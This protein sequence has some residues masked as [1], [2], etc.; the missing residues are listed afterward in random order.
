VSESGQASVA[1]G[2]VAALRAAVDGLLGLDLDCLSQDE[3][4]TLMRGVETQVG[5]CAA[6][7]AKLVAESTQRGVSAALRFRGE[8]W[9]LADLHRIAVRQAADRLDVADRFATRRTLTGQPL[10]PKYPTA[11]AA[12]SDGTI[13]LAHA[14][15]IADTVEH[16][17]EPLR[18]ERGVEVEEAL[19]GHA[20]DTDVRGLRVL[21][22]RVV[23]TLFPDGR[24]PKDED[25]G[26][27]A[28]RDLTL[29]A[30][31]DGSG[32]L[33]ARLTPACLAI[34]QAALTPLAKKPAADPIGGDPRTPGQ[35]WHDA[36]EEAGR[37]LLA[38]GDLPDHAGVH[39]KLI[40]TIGLKDLEQR[41][42]RATTHHG[43]TL[44]VDEALRLAAG[45]EVVPVVLGDGG[46][47]LAYGRKYRLATKG[48]RDALFA[49]DR[50]CSFPECSKPAAKSEVHHV[51]DWVKGGRT[52]IDS[53]ALACGFHN[54]ETPRLGWQT[55]MIDHIPH[56][57]PPRW[58][59]PEQKPIRNYLHHPELV[60]KPQP[61]PP[62]SGTEIDPPPDM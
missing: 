17:P 44:T 10:D 6:V 54:N 23:A 22:Q 9:F 41:I 53:L 62:D 20:K 37:R 34:W 4:L 15:V 50:G 26:H 32:Y 21:A 2:A 48:Q 57:K 30:E 51:T 39:T 58:K 31:P 38:S 14:M 27:R 29:C 46:G 19:T 47:I 7:D 3:L 61:H 25:G 33:K 36:F 59:D 1:G 11:S 56:W 60:V 55:L 12:I 42:G 49:R 40:V 16:L 43:G 5:R 28:D 8:K 13:S 24:E 52:N 18:A 45:Q 35:R